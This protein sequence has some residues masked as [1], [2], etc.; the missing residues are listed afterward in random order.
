MSV[1]LTSARPTVLVIDDEPRVRKAICAGLAAGGF[2]VIE[3][4]DAQRALGLVETRTPDVVV[5]DMAMHPPN[6]LEFIRELRA[7]SGWYD[8]PIIVLSARTSTDARVAALAQGADDVVAKPYAVRE[9]NARV[10]ALLE[11]RP[12]R[13]VIEIS[14]DRSRRVDTGRARRRWS[15]P[16]ALLA[17][18]AVA[19][20]TVASAFLA[21]VTG[22]VVVAIVACVVIGA[23][24]TD[25]M[26]GLV[27]G[28]TGAAAVGLLLNRS[29]L[30]GSSGVRADWA[31]PAFGIGVGVLVM[32]GAL[33]GWW[34]D[35]R[36]R[37]AKLAP[38]ASS[39]ARRSIGM[40]SEAAGVTR[41]EEEIARARLYDRPL[42]V[43]SITLEIRDKTLTT[44]DV[45]RLRRAVA[46]TFESALDPADIPYVTGDR[47]FAVI[48]PEVSADAAARVLAPAVTLAGRATFA[49]RD[50]GRR[51]TVG[52]VAEVV[53]SID[54]AHVA[55]TGG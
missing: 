13:R 14:V 8:L 4:G 20:G 16:L 43:A 21:G 41:L 9:L 32:C 44:E 53:V 7:R 37:R 27:I 40:L 50:A 54:D 48:L 22:A 24:V 19:A 11:R 42:A 1:D 25:G 15:L 52:R 38:D 35:R 17:L 29:G 47:S 26:G 36:R 39:A 33:V 30:L 18:V 45:E 55:G 46:R 51:V 12:N 23:R 10:H 2:N 31:Y 5:T 49:V 28:L 34:A 3:A 6:G